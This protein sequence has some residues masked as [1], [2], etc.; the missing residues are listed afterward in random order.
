MYRLSASALG[1]LASAPRSLPAS[2]YSHHFPAI[3]A[4]NLS[5]SCGSLRFLSN[6]PP[7]DHKSKEK[8]RQ[9]EEIA[10]AESPIEPSPLDDLSSID[11]A[12]TE[13]LLDFLSEP[14]AADS[15]SS[16]DHREAVASAVASITATPKRSFKEVMQ[17]K[18]HNLPLL[19][20]FVC[21]ASKNGGFVPE[22][23]HLLTRALLLL[24][25]R[26]NQNPA[27]LFQVAIQNL[28]P[29][30]ECGS[31]KR[32][33]K[34]IRVPLPLVQYR[35]ENMAMRWLCAKLRTKRRPVVPWEER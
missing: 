25:Q 6:H 31:Y 22:M 32:G 8:V 17:E 14:T 20:R 26:T 5:G 10:I 15:T 18:Q 21:I 29:V 1:R 11:I 16:S 13:S 12:S 9:L 33:A 19:K 27:H 7:V 28:Q 34:M 30:V 23:H 35:S 4:I 3:S 24:Q 2:L